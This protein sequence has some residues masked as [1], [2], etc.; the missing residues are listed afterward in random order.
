MFNPNLAQQFIAAVVASGDTMAFNEFGD[1]TKLFAEPDRP[2]YEYVRNHVEHYGKLPAPDTMFKETGLPC[3]QQPEPPE[4]YFERI[5]RRHLHFEL[6]RVAQSALTI[7]DTDYLKFDVDGH[8]GALREQI[9]TLAQEGK[10]SNVTDY[11]QNKSLAVASYEATKNAGSPDSTRIMT[12]FK[13]VDEQAGGIGRTDVLSVIGRPGMGKSWMLLS[14]G[15]KAWRGDGVDPASRKSVMLCSMEM[16]RALLAERLAAIETKLSYKWI[17][18]G[19]LVTLTGEEQKFK[20][21]AAEKEAGAPPFWL[22]DA[23][24]YDIEEIVALVR[25]YRPDVVIIDGAYLILVPGEKDL[26]RRV[27]VIATDLKQRVAKYAPVIASFQF[28]RGTKK[29]GNDDVD[30]DDIGYSDTIGQHSSVILGMF[31][32]EDIGTVKVRTVRLLKGRKG[33]TGEFQ[34]NWIFS[35]KT[36]ISEVTEDTAPDTDED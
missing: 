15:L 11:A 4:F 28:K 2:F 25:I 12:G 21:Y 16:P 13:F 1:I 33:E 24:G 9:D 7:K 23:L 10:R 34:I 31:Q 27:A 8:L 19:G 35:H 3:Q 5:R 36:D 17:A 29:K 22:V 14:M 32:P 6:A 30:L 26:Y 18:K 20:A